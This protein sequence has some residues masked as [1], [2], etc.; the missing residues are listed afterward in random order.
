MRDRI[1]L[2]FLMMA[3]VALLCVSSVS[4]QD[5]AKW[6]GTWKMIPEKSQF[7]GNG[8]PAS[9]VIK[10]ELKDS[11][12]TETMTL[13]GENGERSFTAKYST[14]GK[15]STQEVMG[16]SAQTSAKWEGEALIINFNADGNGFR[17]KI[18]LSPDGKTM[19]IAVHH[20]GDQGERDETVVLEK[21]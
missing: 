5:S 3:I 13:G 6:T 7:G 21:Q 12:L 15:E 20:S 1:N 9:I 4:A 10:F 19:T 16:K 8:G 18:T 14:D 11:E 2:C 17:R